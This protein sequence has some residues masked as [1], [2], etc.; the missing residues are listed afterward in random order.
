MLV[1]L[2]GGYSNF[3]FSLSDFIVKFI[4]VALDLKSAGRRFLTSSKNHIPYDDD[5]A[6]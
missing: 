5:D 2:Y 6:R 1:C 3:Y 4:L